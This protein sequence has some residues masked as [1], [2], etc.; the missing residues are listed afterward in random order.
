MVRLED[1]AHLGELIS[2]ISTAIAVGVAAYQLRR[3]RRERVGE[4][5][6]DAAARAIV[7]LRR[8][9]H[10]LQRGHVAVDSAIA[11]PLH[12]DDL[13]GARDAARGAVAMLKPKVTGVVER[14]QET[15]IASAAL[16]T[17][18]ET[19]ALGQ[20]QVLAE[21]FIDNLEINVAAL[22]NLADDDAKTRELLRD[23]VKGA[24]QTADAAVV[25]GGRGRDLL[26]PIVEFRAK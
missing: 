4:R 1:A 11:V 14:L 2:G 5:R 26:Q 16:L 10:V 25:E 15:Q 19:H 23:I 22:D 13:G 24:V 20:V 12:C 7:E 8:C 6:S 21:V 9:G 18:E 3:W 17:N